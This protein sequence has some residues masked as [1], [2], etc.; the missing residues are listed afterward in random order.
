[1]KKILFNGCSF[2]AGNELVWAQYCLEHGKP[3][4]V[5][6]HP[7]PDYNRL[8]F[9]YRYNYRK[10]YN[11]PAL[12]SQ[13]LEVD[14]IDISDDGNSNDMI[15]IATIGYLSKLTAAERQQYHVCI[16]WSHLTRLMKYSKTTNPPSFYNLLISDVG[17]NSD[18]PT[19]NELD[20]Y[21]VSAIAKSYNEDF[22]MNYAKNI[23]LLENYLIANGITYT[24]YRSLGSSDDMKN[25][26]LGLLSPTTLPYIDKELFS[27]PLNW[28]KFDNADCTLP[29]HLGSSWNNFIIKKSLSE[30]TISEK[31][32]HP[33][34]KAIENFSKILAQFIQQQN[35]L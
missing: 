8:S 33:N 29:P 2:V 34:M 12:I 28:Y 14:K 10:N 21:I 19:L 6:N 16:G 31:N 27:N 26:I 11:L 32:V 3:D 22:F 25:C 24:F 13:I 5:W 7:T 35:V 9:D 17:H 23:M 30:L 15:S 18:N 1:M 20:H 4:L